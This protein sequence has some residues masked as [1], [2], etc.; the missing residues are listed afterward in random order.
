MYDAAIKVGGPLKEHCPKPQMKHLARDWAPVPEY[1]LSLFSWD[2]PLK[3]NWKHCRLN[4]LGTLKLSAWWQNDAWFFIFI[5]YAQQ[6]TP[7]LHFTT[8]LLSFFKTII[9]HLYH[10]SFWGCLW[11]EAVLNWSLLCRKRVSDTSNVCIAIQYDHLPIVL[12]P[13]PIT[14]SNTPLKVCCGIWQPRC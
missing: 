12:V 4:F 11:L 3:K 14:D 9:Q 2:I 10:L 5:F 8:K 6:P 13:W 1:E 7:I